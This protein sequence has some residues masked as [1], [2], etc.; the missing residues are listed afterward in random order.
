MGKVLLD[1][2]IDALGLVLTKL[3]IVRYFGID[4]ERGCFRCST[5]AYRQEFFHDR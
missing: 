4:I 5:T 3:A 2:G 1:G